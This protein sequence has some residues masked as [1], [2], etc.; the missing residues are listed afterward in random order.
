MSMHPAKGPA[1][2]VWSWKLKLGVVAGILVVLLL[3]AIGWGMFMFTRLTAADPTEEAV[4]ISFLDAKSA[5]DK[6]RLLEKAGSTKGYVTL[7]ETEINSLLNWI[8]FPTTPKP[9]SKLADAPAYL[10]RWEP[11]S[12]SL[13]P[14]DTNKVCELV[15]AHVHLKDEGIVWHAKVKRS[16]FLLKPAEF[17][18]D[19]TVKLER[20]KDRW[21]FSTQ[22]MRLG[23]C[24]IPEKGA[25]LDRG[26]NF[27]LTFFCKGIPW[28]S[29]AL[30]PRALVEKCLG[31]ADL[32]LEAPFAWLQAL[33]AMQLKTN[34]FQK[35]ELVIYNYPEPMAL[36]PQ[37]P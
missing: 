18:W 36:P 15:S 21:T 29:C 26:I 6:L 24:D 20:E 35:I 3:A 19:R 28:G 16:V 7:K 17:P 32:K 25:L 34:E 33:P 22:T 10:R 8:F 11:T 9:M 4:S 2:G 14:A 1:I 5:V 27:I 30:E 12:N 37:S 13:N 23:L 31:E